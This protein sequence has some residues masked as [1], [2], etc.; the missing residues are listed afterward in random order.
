MRVV[1]FGLGEAGSVIASDL[2]ASGTEVHA[3]DPAAVPTPHGVT[4]HTDPR[5]AVEGAAVVMSITSAADSRSAMDQAWDAI[6]RPT[7]YADL[8]TAAPGLEE[9]LADVAAQKGVLFADV[10]LMAPVSGRGLGTPA[11]AAGTGAESLSDLLN[12]L[13]A[14][15]EAIGETAGQASARK[16]TRSVITKGLAALIIESISAAEARG[17]RDW[18]REHI[19][20]LITGLDAD[21]VIRLIAGTEKHGLRRLEEMETA[22]MFLESLGVEPHMTRATVE[23]LRPYGAG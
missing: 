13:G 10:A 20:E 17:D 23:R 8:A 9:E 22:A 21:M 2:A 1:I 15:L 7:I 11:L 4:R 12:P 5:E 6:D 19:D 3:F 14:R 18:M 16:L